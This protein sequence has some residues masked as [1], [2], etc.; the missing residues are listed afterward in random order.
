MLLTKS[1]LS[2][3][4]SAMQTKVHE[5]DVFNGSDTHKL[6]PFLV[7]CTLNFHNHPDMFTSDS[8]K[9]TFMLSY[10]KGTTCQGTTCFP[11]PKHLGVFPTLTSDTFGILQTP[12]ASKFQR[13]FGVL[14]I[15]RPPPPLKV[16]WR[17]LRILH[18]PIRTPL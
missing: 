2:L 11:L 3:K 7:Q 13:H 18:P 5:P 15:P 14:P 16:T 12:T 8:D 9:V 17:P 10:L 6:Q 1:L 4:K